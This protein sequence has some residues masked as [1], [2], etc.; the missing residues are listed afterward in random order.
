[1]YL[2][3]IMLT[4]FILIS[5]LMI[6]ISLIL[7]KKS[8]NEMEKISPFECGFDPHS[9][10][11][12]AFS[13][14]FFLITIIFLIFDVEIA[15]LIPIIMIFTVSNLNKWFFISSFFIIILIM[16]LYYEWNQNMLNWT[17]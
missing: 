15:I 3:M 17:N 6:F 13:I 8:T 1:M 2:M 16:G 7:N 10:P 14:H 4:V 12:I 11:R 9:S 5:N